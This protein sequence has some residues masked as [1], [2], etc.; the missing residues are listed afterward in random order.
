[1]KIIPYSTLLSLLRPEDGVGRRLA[2]APADGAE[3][4]RAGGS[5]RGG[6]DSLD[7]RLPA[8]LVLDDR[9]L[10]KGLMLIY[11]KNHTKRRE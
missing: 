6:D 2:H 5:G 11:N 9:L 4:R 7:A 1:M 8:V 3:E 10:L